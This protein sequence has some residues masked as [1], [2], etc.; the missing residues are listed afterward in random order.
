[1]SILKPKN[2]FRKDIRDLSN[3]YG[4]NYELVSELVKWFGFSEITSMLKMKPQDLK[5]TIRF[6]KL[7]TS[8]NEIMDKLEKEEITVDPI[9]ELDEGLLVT[10]GWKKVGSSLA[11]LSGE[12]MPQ[13]LGSMLAIEA[14]D[15]Q[16]GEKILDMAAAPGGKSC[17]IAERMM[18]KGELVVNDISK[19]RCSALINNLSRHHVQNYSLSI[20]DGAN[21]KLSGFDRI[22][23]DAPC[24]GDGLIVSDIRRRNSTKILKSFALQKIQ[25]SL[26]KRAVV[27]LKPNGYCVYATCALTPIENELVVQNILGDVT[28]ESIDI[29]GYAGIGEIN[30][31]FERAKRLLPSSH[32]CD[33]FFI[34][35]IRKRNTDES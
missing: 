5:K 15:P 17:F 23:L 7:K 13:G 27:M 24:S 21:L 29:P 2:T 28:I 6:N 25:F 8:K 34:I 30:P 16:P 11:Y 1:M 9:I 33:G 3:K 31:L 26:L 12:I 35:K 10:S 20:S 22:L 19:N 18:G 14:L 4:T 32:G